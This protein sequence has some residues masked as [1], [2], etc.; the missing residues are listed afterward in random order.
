MKSRSVF[1]IRLQLKRSK[2]NDLLE[3]VEHLPGYCGMD[4]EKDNDYGRDDLA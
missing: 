4:E 2:G 3:N 1:S